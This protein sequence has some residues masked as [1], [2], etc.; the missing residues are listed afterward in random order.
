MLKPTLGRIP[1]ATAGEPG[2][3]IGEQLMVVVGPMARTV[4]DLRAAF[5]VMAGPSWRDPWSVPAPLRSPEPGKPVHVALVT[6]PAGRGTAWQ[7]QDGVR[8]AA[9]ALQDAGYLIEEIEPP[10]IQAAADAGLAM[11]NTPEVRARLPGLNLLPPDTA[12]FLSDFYEAAGDPGPAA[13][14]QGL[15]AR[16]G[17]RTGPKRARRTFAIAGL[18]GL[19]GEVLP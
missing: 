6:D 13:A 7:V 19:T 14:M 2:V 17:R 8:T 9:A 12:R 15:T 4:A 11:L 18:P 3:P 1:A 16:P 5:A 10:S